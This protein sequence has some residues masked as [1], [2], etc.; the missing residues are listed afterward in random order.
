MI[1][2][3]VLID[4]MAGFRLT[5][6]LAILNLVI[7]RADFQGD[8]TIS[9]IQPVVDIAMPILVLR[10]ILNTM[11]AELDAAEAKANLPTHPTQQ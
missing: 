6:G 3:I 4:G 8:K 10:Q 9:V 2:P 7:V 11:T 1:P 5:S